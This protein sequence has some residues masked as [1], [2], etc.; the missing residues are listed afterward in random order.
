MLFSTL[1]DVFAA[2]VSPLVQAVRKATSL[3]PQK[4]PPLRVAF[5]IYFAFR[6]QVTL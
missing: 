3:P 2:Q 6:S 5:V 4:L 1:R